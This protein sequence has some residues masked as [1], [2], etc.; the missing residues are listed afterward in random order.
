MSDGEDEG[1]SGPDAGGT[2]NLKMPDGSAAPSEALQ[3]RKRQ[4]EIAAQLLA[5]ASA[6]KAKKEKKR[7][8]K[9]RDKSE[10]KKSSKHKKEKHKHKVRT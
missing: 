8:K 3:A 5:E 1:P 2:Y 4:A 10:K 9:E 6:K 7:D